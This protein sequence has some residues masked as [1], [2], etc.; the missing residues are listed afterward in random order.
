VGAQGARPVHVVGWREVATD[1]VELTL[2]P[3]T[4]AFPAWEPGSHVDVVLRDGTVRQYS[5]CGDLADDGRWTIAVLRS[6]HPD[7]ASRRVLEQLRPGAGAQLHGPRNRFELVEADRYIFVA[8]GIGITPLLP[9][10][11]TVSTQDRPWHLYYGGRTAAH[12]AYAERLTEQHPGHVTLWPQDRSGLLDLAALVEGLPEGTAVYA[13][14]PE[15]MLAAFETL[16]EGAAWSFH[17]ERFARSEKVDHEGDGPIEVTLAASD[18]ELTVQPGESI[19]EVVERAGVFVLSSCREG[20]CGSCET[21]VI[22]GEIEHRDE[23]LTQEEREAGEVM[24][25]CVSRARGPLE[26]DL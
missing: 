3:Q 4:G 1:V 24:M 21:A 22:S 8:G 10:I 6:D 20:I 2:E 17:S 7:G 12:M 25:I 13:C 26:L 9:M 23:Y 19:L 5:L 15:G 11:A 18:M 14:G 16:A